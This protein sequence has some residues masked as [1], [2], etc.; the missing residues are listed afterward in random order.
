MA[1]AQRFGIFLDDELDQ[2]VPLIF[3]IPFSWFFNYI[4]LK[5]DQNWWKF[6]KF[7]KLPTK[8]NRNVKKVSAVKNTHVKKI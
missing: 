5:I 7:L 1:I 2:Y 4:Q 8:L 3:R 6:W